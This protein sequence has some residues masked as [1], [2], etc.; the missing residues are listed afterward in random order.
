MK[1]ALTKLCSNFATVVVMAA[2]VITAS[3]SNP[4][5]QNTAT[6]THAFADM[7]LFIRY[8]DIASVS[9]CVRQ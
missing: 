6:L 5:K 2:G 4:K 9:A 8:S 7:P 3:A 1:S